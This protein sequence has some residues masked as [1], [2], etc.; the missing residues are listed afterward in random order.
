[1]V[2]G[3]SMIQ[4]VRFFFGWKYKDENLRHYKG[5]NID[6]WQYGLTSLKI[7][8]PENLTSHTSLTSSQEQWVTVLK[9]AIQS[10]LKPLKKC[11]ETAFEVYLRDGKDWKCFQ[12]FALCCC[13]TPGTR[14]L[15]F[16][17]RRAGRLRTC[18]R[19]KVG[20]KEMVHRKRRPNLLPSATSE[21]EEKWKV[22]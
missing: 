14:V 19:C 15:F 22:Q 13:D 1:M 6:L 10:I 5:S 7:V 2:P 21:R 8:I 3:P 16:L 11:S 17:R 4:V 18:L 12:K 9:E 20:F